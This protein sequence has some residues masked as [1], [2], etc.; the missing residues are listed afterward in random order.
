MHARFQLRRVRIVQ[1]DHP[2]E[3]NRSKLLG[4]ASGLGLLIAAVAA[5]VW[6]AIAEGLVVVYEQPLLRP[7][8]LVQIAALLFGALTVV[9]TS[10]VEREFRFKA[11][12]ICEVGVTLIAITVSLTG[13]LLGWGLWVLAIG[14]SVN[15]GARA[16]L[17]N[18][19]TRGQPRPRWPRSQRVRRFLEFGFSVAPSRLMYNL[20]NSIDV[21]IGGR[22]LS[23]AG[24]GFYNVAVYWSHVPLGKMMVVL[25]QAL[26]PFFA[27]KARGEQTMVRETE[28]L[29]RM[30]AMLALPVFWGL[31]AVAES[32]VFGLLGEKWAGV[33]LPLHVL[34]L[35]IPLRMVLESVTNPLQA[36]RGLRVML[37]NHVGSLATVATGCLIGVG[38]GATGL[39]LGVA[40]GIMVGNLLA[41]NRSLRWLGCNRWS[42]L[43]S[44]WRLALAA[45]LMAVTVYAGGQWLDAIGV[46]RVLTLFCQ[47][48]LGGLIYIP[49]VLLLERPL[50]MQVI[51]ALRPGA[52]PAPAAPPAPAEEPV[53]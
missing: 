8:A 45:A 37:K 13:A 26:Y 17:Y 14:H 20:E 49:L 44:M 15:T 30:V 16:I 23:P 40:G 35:V 38:Y 27:A 2:G 21:V 24:L 7:I 42:L 51:G 29:V 32:L 41:L 11:M 19:A 46:P 1:S 18:I 22:F 5:V 10:L 4:E 6:I 52:A 53:P 48:P 28:N 31:S 47:I 36:A 33:L 34:C 25:N 9:P 50:A 3:A 43:V 12:A 39:A